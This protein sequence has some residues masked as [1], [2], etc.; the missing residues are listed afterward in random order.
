MKPITLHPLAHNAME[1]MMTHNLSFGEMRR[2]ALQ[3]AY[4][5]AQFTDGLADTLRPSDL[6]REAMS[7]DGDAR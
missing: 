3:I 5:V 4:L 6:V 7:E 1:E 2:V